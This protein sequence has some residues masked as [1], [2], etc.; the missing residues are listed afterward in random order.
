MAEKF[1]L[2]ILTCYK[3][4]DILSV[5][6]EQ[7][8]SVLGTESLHSTGNLGRVCENLVHFHAD[9]LSRQESV[10]KPT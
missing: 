3:E 8:P 2:R 9:L 5:K 4:P 7:P 6:T 10:E 1:T